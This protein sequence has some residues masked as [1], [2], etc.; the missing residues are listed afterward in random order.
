MGAGPYRSMFPSERYEAI[1]IQPTPAPGGSYPGFVP[2]RPIDN[3]PADDGVF[4]VT[5][6]IGVLERTPEPQGLMAELGRTLATGG[7]LFLAAP[8]IV[9]EP[10]RARLDSRRRFGLNYLLEA[11]G[12]TIEDLMPIERESAYGVVASK[13]RPTGAGRRKGDRLATGSTST[14]TTAAD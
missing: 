9:P 13:R 3:L 4:G 8:L 14:S 1:A 7:Q 10:S 5:L 2:F 6:C 12:F 11:A